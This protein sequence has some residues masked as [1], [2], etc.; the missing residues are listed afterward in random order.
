[1]DKFSIAVNNKVVKNNPDKFPEGYIF[2]L[3][4]EE[5]AP[6]KSKFSAS[7]LGGGKVKRPKAFTEKG[8][9]TLAT[10]LKSTTTFNFVIDKLLK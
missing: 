6:V 7:P 4:L 2:E 5:W 10:I 1:M 8:L 9:Y 3:T